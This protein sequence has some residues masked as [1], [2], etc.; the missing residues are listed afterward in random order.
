VQYSDHIC[1]AL[2]LIN[3]LQDIAID[4][5]KN[6]GKQRIYLCQDELKAFGIT[7]QTIGAY[8]N[9]TQA[10]DDHWHQFMHFNLRRTHALLNMGKPLG[11]ILKGRIGFE[12][13][14]IIAGGE[15]I[16]HKISAVNGDVFN[17]RPTLNSW[18]WA[19]VFSK[20]LLKR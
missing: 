7:E 11:K 15:R 5:R 16:I 10:T 18:D 20:A 13:R 14:M 12:M 6:E 3:F 2:Q 17:H 9:A 8:V 4:F 19:I 1:S